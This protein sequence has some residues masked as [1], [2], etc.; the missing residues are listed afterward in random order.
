MNLNGVVFWSEDTNFKY[1]IYQPGNGTS[2]EL[3]LSLLDCN[4]F[5]SRRMSLPNDAILVTLLNW[6]T[7]PSLVLDPNGGYLS[8]SYV[9]EKL[10]IGEGDVLPVTRVI[11]AALGWKTNAE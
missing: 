2:Y 8:T 1:V 9:E 7:R 10:R 3:V 11:A 6:P 4:D 5:C